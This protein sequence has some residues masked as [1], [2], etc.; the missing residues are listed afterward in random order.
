MENLDGWIGLFS[1][2]PALGF[3]LWLSHRMTTHTIPRLA[4]DFREA[5]KLQRDD[6]REAMDLQRADFFALLER[7]REVH[8]AQIDRLVSAIGN[9]QAA[10]AGR[11]V[12]DKTTEAE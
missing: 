11:N 1:N 12:G 3:V 10:A 8:Q 7:E 5:V 9:C 6:F 2:V 4:G